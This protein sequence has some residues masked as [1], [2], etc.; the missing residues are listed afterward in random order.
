MTHALVAVA[1]ALVGV[2]CAPPPPPAP[3]PLPA[4]KPAESKPADQICF[5]SDLTP[6][7]ES[8]NAGWPD[9]YRPTG[10]VLAAAKGRTVYSRAFGFADRW[11]GVSPTENTSFRI[12]PL[13]KGFTAV[14]VL[15]LV[16]AG[17]LRLDGKIGDYLPEYP[18]VG[19]HVTLH[20]LLTH[21][22]GIPN[23]TDFP[24]YVEWRQLTVQPRQILE[25]FWN[26]PLEFEPGSQ[27]R[28]SNS[29]YQVLGAII[30]RVSGQK[31]AEYLEQ[32]VFAPAGLGH[33]VVGDA[34]GFK[35]RA[36][37]YRPTP[38]GEL[39]LSSH[40]D[41][42]V[43]FAAGGIRSSAADLARWHM[44]LSGGTLLNQASLERMVPPEQDVYAYGWVVH[45][46]AGVRVLQQNGGI[47]GF[48]SRIVRVPSLD[49]VIVVLSNT[50]GLPTEPI[51]DAALACAR[52]E[53]LV[54]LPVESPVE[55]DAPARARLL[56][57]YT[58]EDSARR[59]LSK[60]QTP[61]MIESVSGIT[62]LEREGALTMKPS[63]RGS[64]RIVAVSPSAVVVK[65]IDLRLDFDLPED[66]GAPAR[67]LVLRQSGL[68]V[69]YER[70]VD[71]AVPNSR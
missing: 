31:Y 10:M 23:F 32:H 49:L 63:G 43:P 35:D 16:Q 66:S 55:L 46:Q 45:E 33:T 57:E 14:A 44:A 69:Q 21:T 67:G 51:T 65:A 58:L 5:E 27:H 53:H 68:E 20:Q 62:V 42:T 9:A 4:P 24:E 34:G 37:G 39:Q 50:E 18:N 2:A 64:L 52:G 12:G 29:G 61:E 26:R 41:M 17:K 3:A 11:H 60:T 25:W 59:E 6:Y 30:E 22:S 28:Y 47:D 48:S 70:R 8:I 40:V 38:A 1:S 56:G 54:P 19:R 13:S 36:L 7:I 15:Q 71:A